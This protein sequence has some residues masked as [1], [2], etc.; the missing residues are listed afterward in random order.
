MTTSFAHLARTTLLSCLSVAALGSVAGAGEVRYSADGHAY[1]PVWSLDGKTLAFEVNAYDDGGISLYFAKVNGAVASDG[2][3]VSL[4]GNSG[5]YGGN[6]VVANPTWHPDGI[7][8]FEGSNQ[9]GQYRLYLAQPGGAAATEMLGTTLA[10]GDLTFPVAS[11]DGNLLAFVSDQTGD[12][13]LRTWNR[14]SNKVTQVTN[15]PTGEMFPMFK[16]DGSTLLFTR[17][18]RMAE[19]IFQYN[20]GTGTEQALIQ[21]NGDQT[22]PTYAAGGEKVLYFSN[23]A[24]PAGAEPRW[25]LMVVNSDGTGK[26]VL[27][28]GIRL[29]LRARPAVSPDGKWVAYVLDDPTKGQSIRIVTVDGTKTVE[30]KSEFT[31]CGEPAIGVQGSRILLAYTALPAA[32]ADWRA[33]H[34]VDITSEL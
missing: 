23:G 7:A 34:V 1:N 15:T 12:G 19:D 6:Q 25:D 27:A 2:T 31:A 30:I 13:D 33:L 24:T 16:A 3:I 17:K 18:V 26:Q 22:R 10:P 5:P 8:V 28:K 20:M 32:S 4:P 11:P 21:G 9:G 14:V 29:P